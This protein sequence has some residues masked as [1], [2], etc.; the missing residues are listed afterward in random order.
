MC[1]DRTCKPHKRWTL[2][3][4]AAR[5]RTSERAAGRRTDEG[6]TL[7]E[8]MVAFVVLM[9]A[10][11]PLS[12]LFISS[13][14]QAGQTT[15]QQTA[16]SVADQ[17]IET[18]E[19]ENPPTNS[20]G[21]VIVNHD[22]PPT[23]Q[24]AGTQI[25][26]AISGATPS[27][28]T[29]LTV[30]TTSGFAATGSINVNTLDGLE[31]VSYTAKTATTFTGVSGWSSVT[32][33]TLAYAAV[34]Q[35]SNTVSSE[36]VG[37]TPFNLLAEYEW[38]SVQGASN[39]TQPNLCT[40]GT[41][42]LLKVQVTVSWGPNVDTN[43]VQESQVINYPAA[44]IQSL[45][46]LAL[47]VNG[48]STALDS[49]QNAWSVRVQAPP[50][51]FTETASTSSIVQ[52]ALTVYPDANGCAFVQVGPGTYTVGI[53]NASAGQPYVNDTYGTPSFV[54]NT[55]GPVTNN[56]MAQ[57][58]SYTDTGVTVPVGAVTHVAV[59]YD[60]GSP[61]NVSF[62]SAT[63]AE[64]GVT[65]PGVGVLTCIAT[66]ESGTGSGVTATAALSVYSQTTG[67]WTPQSLPSGV[68]MTRITSVACATTGSTTTRCIAVGFGSSG[69]VILS[70]GTSSASFTADTLPTGVTLASLSTVV[71]PSSAQCVAIG[72]TSAG[73]AAVISGAITAATDT[74]TNNPINPASTVVGLSSLVCPAGAG[75]CIALGA[76]ASSAGAPVIVSGQYGTGGWTESSPNPTGVTL[77]A[78]T[79]L[80][81]PTSG[82]PTTC[83]ITGTTSGSAPA[84]VAGSAPAG[85]GSTTPAWTWTS[86]T[87]PSG[88]TLT[89]IT[90]LAC[91]STTECLVTG[92]TSP[93]APVVLYGPITASAALAKD[94]IPTAPAT[95]TTLGA[96]TCP[97]TTACVLLGT[98]ASGPAIL[99]GTIMGVGTADSWTEDTLPT[100]PT[101][102]TLTTLTSVSCATNLSCMVTGV[103]TNTS[104]VAAGFLLAT[105]ASTMTWSAIGLPKTNPVLFL[106]GAQC[107]R[108]GTGICSAVGAGPSGAAE[109]ISTSGPT[110]S[111]ADDTP[112]GL[113]GLTSTGIPIEI[114]NGN[115][116]PNPYQ[117]LITPGWSTQPTNP[118]PPLYPFGSGYSVFAGDCQTESQ[119]G[120]NVV[121]DPTVPG[122][123]SS[124]VVPMGLIA[125]QV[126]HSTGNSTGLPYAT[127]SIKLV[128]TAASPCG[129][130]TYTLQNA[131]ADGL[132][133]TEVP[134]GTYTLT[135]VT[136]GGTT[137]VSNV[138]VGGSSVTVGVSPVN[139]YPLP[140]PITEK[141]P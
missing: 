55:A 5:I 28:V 114:N 104:T 8:V 113:G 41:P 64:D 117:T 121:Q 72:T 101:G 35:G 57:P 90:G 137:T 131:G 69:A 20:L 7:I 70:S 71:C 60:Q 37:G 44:G 110:S 111:W 139:T 53:A 124:V 118:L 24:A 52:P 138:T 62:S 33:N 66:G 65:C 17:W 77:T 54:E 10:M 73:Y 108:P 46:F 15:T 132:S 22:N 134:F 135:I 112:A 92:A 68:S 18:L 61:L 51:T 130:D 34:T 59:A 79:N 40:V 133:R 98:T 82:T 43:N 80:A 105:S 11:I 122:A 50:V 39:G 115:L 1:T 36:T 76:S 12:Y 140:T 38:T 141:V 48:D 13:T 29:T 47:Q 116:A 21:E 88:T 3:P 83:L 26:L 14:I 93:T 136:A 25:P 58:T 84:V 42:S 127:T 85:L 49:Q 81:C 97:S 99:S 9:I 123:T 102:Y 103:G 91:P 96:M 128:S 75:G 63:A 94:T 87:F 106:S 107:T 74:W 89:S 30:A 6:V 31:T 109:L 2:N 45:G 27:S 120:L 119:T 32:V 78:S 95:I 56:V 100:Q 129:T 126:L 4:M 86:D 125:V 19:N 67:V 23:T 16:L